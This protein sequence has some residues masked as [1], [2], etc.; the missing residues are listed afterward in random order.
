MQY[1]WVSERKGHFF[2]EWSRLVVPLLS[3]RS[4][5]SQYNREWVFRALA[6]GHGRSMG[7]QRLYYG[8]RDLICELPGL[9]L[10][11]HLQRL[12]EYIGTP[13]VRSLYEIHKV[14]VLPEYITA[15]LCME[16]GLFANR[17]GRC[18]AA[19]LRTQLMGRCARCAL[20]HRN[21]EYCRFFARTHRIISRPVH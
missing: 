17:I 12:Q 19:L 9:D 2:D 20:S 15:A 13:L 7:V 4:K 21:A 11:C 18:K 16:G 1:F 3:S 14:V 8:K 5:R 6:I 10:H